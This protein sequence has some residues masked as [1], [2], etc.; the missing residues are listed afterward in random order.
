V[1][2][3][4]RSPSLS[5]IPV[6]CREHHRGGE[7]ISPRQVDVQ[8]YPVWTIFGHGGQ[9]LVRVAGPADH[10]QAARGEQLGCHADEAWIV[11]NNQDPNRHVAILTGRLAR[12]NRVI[13][14]F[15]R[16]A[17]LTGVHFPGPQDKFSS[18]KVYLACGRRL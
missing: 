16:S 17:P 18:A 3:A 12:A 11:I 14:R 6:T 2:G 7:A 13:P 5:K 10:L 1:S 9:R 15:C 8:Q 4:C